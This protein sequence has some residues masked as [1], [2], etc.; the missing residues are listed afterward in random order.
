MKIKIIK[1]LLGCSLILT[2]LAIAGYSLVEP[3]GATA[4]QTA[5]DSVI[6][7]LNVDQGIAISSPAD[8]T[9]SPNIGVSQD[10]SVTNTVWNVK[11]N[12]ANGYFL[13]LKASTAPA[14]QQT[15]TTTV[16]DYQTGAP[17]T[18]SVSNGAAFGYS[19]YGN[20]TPTGTWGTDTDCIAG[21]GVPSTTLKYKGFTTSTSTTN[22][23]TR[24]ATTTTSGTDTTVCYAAQ[25][26]NF[27]IPS[28]TYT[29]TITAT[30]V[31]N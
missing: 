21:A 20:D 15:S 31:G 1:K 8:A 16:A 17:N 2:V 30:A 14:L 13:N 11:T 6:I 29:A 28:G 12:D 3:E 22:V 4:A 7:T 10:T 27:Y 19:A 23:A 25:Q 26:N 5:S 18:W 24:T 9:F